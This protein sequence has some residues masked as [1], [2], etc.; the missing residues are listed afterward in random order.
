MFIQTHVPKAP[1]SEF[2]DMFWFIEQD[3]VA[4]YTRERCLPTGTLE[5]VIN[6]RDDKLRIYDQADLNRCDSYSNAMVCGAHTKYFVIDTMP[7]ERIIGVHFKPGGAFPFLKLPAGE[8]QDTHVS[9]DTLW[10]SA[11]E[12]LREQLLEAGTPRLQFRLLEQALMRQA[13]RRLTR[14]PAVAFA[15][16]EFHARPQFRTLAEVVE[17]IGLSQRRFIEVFQREA[18]LTPKKFCRVLRFQEALQRLAKPR[19]LAWAQFALEC[20]YYDQAHFIHD[21]QAFSGL[22]PTRYLTVQGERLNHIPLCE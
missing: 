9:L 5:L 20:G 2:V 12:E 7:A 14:H 22:N 6:L 18:G 8:L 21:F 10:G 1:L 17:K 15:L 19:H 16:K 13:A 11:A 3:A 4:P